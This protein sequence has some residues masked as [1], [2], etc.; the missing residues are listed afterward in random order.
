MGT[1]SCQ[2]IYKS[3]V[4]LTFNCYKISYF[5]HFDFNIFVLAAFSLVLSSNTVKHTFI[6]NNKGADL[7]EQAHSLY[8]HKTYIEDLTRVNISYD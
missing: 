3:Y 4:L 5:I 7:T 6:M 8:S 1:F 2:T